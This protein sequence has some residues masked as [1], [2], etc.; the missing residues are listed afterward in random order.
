M[1]RFVSMTRTLVILLLT[2]RV[3][4]SPLAMRP[5]PFRNPAHYRLVARVCAWLAQRPQRSLTATSLVPSFPRK[6]LDDT[7]HRRHGYGFPYPTSSTRAIL[8]L[9]VGSLLNLSR[10]QQTVCLRC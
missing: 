10:C 6:C 2:L 4:A 3:L 7:E 9:F 1:H 8:S 5:E